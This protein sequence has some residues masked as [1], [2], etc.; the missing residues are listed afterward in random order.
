[1]K[2]AY[3]VNGEVLSLRELLTKVQGRCSHLE[4]RYQWAG[5]AIDTALTYLNVGNAKAATEV[6]ANRLEIVKADLEAI[7]LEDRTDEI[8]QWLQS[9][10]EKAG[11]KEKCNA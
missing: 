9:E 8:G 6:L 4:S 10:R 5:S 2:H 3:L 1:M 7:L 11:H